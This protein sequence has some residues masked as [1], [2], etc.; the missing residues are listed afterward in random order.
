MS[1]QTNPQQ[2]EKLA[3]LESRFPL[4]ARIPFPVTPDAVEQALTDVLAA[5]A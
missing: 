3:L 4:F 1:E 2:A 5:D